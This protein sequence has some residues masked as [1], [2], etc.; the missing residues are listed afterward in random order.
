MS[1]EI[2]K[3]RCH[4]FQEPVR[5]Q[6]DSLDDLLVDTLHSDLP[7]INEICEYLALIPGKKIRPSLLFLVSEC[8]GGDRQAA[9]A[10]G[11]AVELIHTATLVHDDILDNHKTRRGRATVYSKYGGNVATIIGD[12]LYSKAFMKLGE[13]ELFEMMDILAAATHKMSVGEL[14]Q[15]QLARQIDMTEEVYME[16]IYSKTASLFAASSE[17]GAVASRSGGRAELREAMSEYGR[18]LG[19][20]FQITDDLFDYL[21]IDN[22]IGKQTAVDFSDGRV[23]LPLIVAM[24]E[25]PREQQADIARLFHEGF[26][27]E[28]W[29][30][31]VMFVQRFG[32]IEYSLSAARRLGEEAR[33]A[34][35]PLPACRERDSLDAAAEYVIR[36]V[37]PFSL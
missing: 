8:T 29:G 35:G 11:L 7:I 4:Y 23:T 13:L 17:C 32:G 1:Y 28:D 30:E 5:P 22:H 2:E 34:L 9:L 18:K 37:D 24:R 10:G 27:D 3:D 15:F 6:M 36:R 31:V 20:A 12:F 19:L 26:G 14:M 21:A 16:M 33:E 25:A